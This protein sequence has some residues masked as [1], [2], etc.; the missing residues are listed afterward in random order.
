VN[1]AL[2]LEGDFLSAVITALSDK[3]VTQSTNYFSGT[4]IGR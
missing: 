3:P 4:A 1:P 2:I